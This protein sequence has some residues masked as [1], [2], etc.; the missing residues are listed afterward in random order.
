[1]LPPRHRMTGAEHQLGVSVAEEAMFGH[2]RL[3]AL[4]G[5]GGMGEVWH[6]HDTRKGRDVALKI[7][8]SWLG[9]NPAYAR[10][11]RREAAL[12]ARL[13]APNI[14]P[15]HDYGEIDSKLF[16]EMPLIVG[17]DLD[18]LIIRE[19]PLD[20]AR[21]VDV[22][23]QIAAA[24]DAAHRAG[25]VH[26]DVKPSNVLVAAHRGR[27]FVYLIDF[28][29]AHSADGTQLTTT[30]RELGTLAYMAPE[31]F[32]GAGDDP[33]GDVYA[34]ACVL[35]QTLT[36][37]APFMPPD[38]SHA[39]AFYLNAHLHLPPPRP[40]VS[41]PALPDMWDEVIARGMAKDP[42]QRYP[43]ADELA[44]AAHSTLTRPYAT[45]SIDLASAARV[46]SVER[47]S[48]NASA[49]KPKAASPPKLGPRATLALAARCEQS[50]DLAKA[51]KVYS[52][53]VNSGHPEVAPMAGFSL[54][55]LLTRIGEETDAL[56]HYQL[57]AESGH[58]DLAA[59][60]MFN[61]GLILST[62]DREQAYTEFE[63][64][65]AMNHPEISPKAA[66]QLGMLCWRRWRF[67]AA[68]RYFR[69][70]IE[71]GNGEVAPMARRNRRILRARVSLNVALLVAMTI[72]VL[73]QVLR[74]VP[75]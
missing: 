27:H 45:T 37:Q 60:A 63:A 75:F 28:G 4:L 10:R 36:G 21:A 58:A 24:L 67:L 38:Q 17:T 1:M 70:A 68:A 41:N 5:Q 71:S 14:I 19:G 55:R 49:P 64:A 40:S 69:T 54:A 11:F 29:I 23:D 30:G 34:L 6:A 13:N 52:A 72:F 43:S 61:A 50:G 18:E 48:N 33:R 3:L 39:L 2:Y 65:M 7:L 15:I 53:A 31:R 32:R 74:I 46:V 56:R 44:V 47:Q 51:R 9:A 62:R 25:L 57:V 22:I 66:N 73:L 35:F 20:P 59:K 8:G 16:M 26:R 12:A 42:E